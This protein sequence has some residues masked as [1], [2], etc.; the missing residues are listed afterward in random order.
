MNRYSHNQQQKMDRLQYG[1]M[2]VF[3]V[4]LFESFI[5]LEFR[6]IELDKLN[7]IK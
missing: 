6:Q 3:L 1:N 4:K 5:M 2:I 7:Q